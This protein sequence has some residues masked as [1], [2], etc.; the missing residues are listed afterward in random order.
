M[1]EYEHLDVERTEGVARIVMDRPA[2]NNAMDRSMASELRTATANVVDG[3]A[4]C[5]VLT[6]SGGAFNAGA[7]LSVLDGDASDA[8]TLRK[9]ASSLHRAI[10]NLVT[11]RKPVVTGV[12]GVAE[13]GRAHV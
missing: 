13:I 8:R 4:R 5:V 11:A 12:N 7:D 1:S 3:D 10:E 9:I 2:T 6:G